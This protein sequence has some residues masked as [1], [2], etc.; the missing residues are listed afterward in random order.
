MEHRPGRALSAEFAGTAVLT[1]VVVGSGLMAANLTHDTAVALLLNAVSTVSALGLLIWALGPISGAHFNPAVSLVMCIRGSLSTAAAAG[2]I[3]AQC[4]GA[5]AGASLAN[6]MY[7]QPALSISGTAR[8]GLGQLLGEFVATAGLL[9]VICMALDR[10]A[11]SQVPVLVPAWIASA[12][13]FTSSTAL[14]NPA[15]TLGRVFSDSFAGIA[16][17]SV[18][19]FATAQAVGALVGVALARVAVSQTKEESHVISQR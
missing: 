19:G 1:A 5:V 6:L 9:A 15:V 8:G 18:G 16:P 11:A 7:E 3:V 10:G 2:Y 4:A 13:L 14:A 17:A 12:C